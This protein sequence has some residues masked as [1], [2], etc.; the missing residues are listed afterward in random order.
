MKGEDGKVPLTDEMGHFLKKKRSLA[1]EIDI[2]GKQTGYNIE[3]KMCNVFL[4][5]L[6]TRTL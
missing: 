1:V 6:C 5:I 4:F 2:V 3:M